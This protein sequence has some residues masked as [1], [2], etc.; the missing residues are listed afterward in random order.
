MGTLL[1]RLAAPLQSWGATSR[2]NKRT[3]EKEPTKSGVLGMLAAALGKRRDDPLDD[4]QNIRFGVRVDQP[5]ELVKDFHTAHTND[6]KHTFTSDR[7]YLADAIFLVGIEA[8]NALLEELE[9]AI[10]NP[11]FPLFLGRRSC[12]PTGSLSLG[13][14]LKESLL[15]ALDPAITP[16]VASEWYQKKT[17]RSKTVVL[18]T[19]FDSASDGYGVRKDVPP[20]QLCSKSAADGYDVREGAAYSVRDLPVSFDQ[21]YRQYTFR[22]VQRKQFILSLKKEEPLE[23]ETEHDA[24]AEIASAGDELVEIVLAETEVK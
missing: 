13:I 2:F 24:L 11:V 21:A 15:D 16:W 3:T 5:G 22:E 8:D 9:Y 23:A 20:E 6:G 4:L 7:Y 10:N 17:R 1:L 12:P 18:D 19:Y 14:R